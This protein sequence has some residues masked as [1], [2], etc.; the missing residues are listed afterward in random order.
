M[1]FG[2]GKR[3]PRII[4]HQREVPTGSSTTEA[5]DSCIVEL[6]GELSEA[7][8]IEA[9]DTLTNGPEELATPMAVDPRIAS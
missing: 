4:P 5:G 8:T 9:P 1:K 3:F 7:K 2:F 6:E